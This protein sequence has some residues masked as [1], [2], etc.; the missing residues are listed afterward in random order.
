MGN[1]QPPTGFGN[2]EAKGLAAG[3]TSSITAPSAAESNKERSRLKDLAGTYRIDRAAAHS[4][5]AHLYLN[6]HNALEVLTTTASAI[7][8]EAR[9]HVDVISSQDKRATGLEDT[10][11]QDV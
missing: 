5:T 11:D 9:A 3:G 6:I 8:A 4:A 10:V 2:R 7:P 1:K